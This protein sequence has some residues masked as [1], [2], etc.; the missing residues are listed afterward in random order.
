[1]S[2]LQSVSLAG[3]AMCVSKP[4]EFTCWQSGLARCSE[5]PI[6]Q[7]FG[8]LRSQ[9]ASA[10]LSARS[11]FMASARQSLKVSKT[12]NHSKP[13]PA[14][15]EK[16]LSDQQFADCCDRALKS[17]L[18]LVARCSEFSEDRLEKMYRKACQNG[19]YEWDDPEEPAENE[20]DELEEVRPAEKPGSPDCIQFLDTLRV[21]HKLMEPSDNLDDVT[22]PDDAPAGP[23][24]DPDLEN[25]M[26]PYRDERFISPKSGKD[27]NEIPDT[28][29][30]ALKLKD[31]DMWNRLW[32]LLLRLRSGKGGIDTGF[33]KNAKNSRKASR[34]LNWYQR[35]S[36]CQFS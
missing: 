36:F 4:S 17:S 20:D 11:F 13:K 5:L 35:L 30:E 18:M 31:G 14:K 9:S 28:L 2:T 26:E 27:G 23:E 3:V 16:P 6:E 15:A 33:L 21:D 22:V 1:M 19:A 7:H 34:G 25:V 12:L 8:H 32:R 24:Q 10:Q 29:L